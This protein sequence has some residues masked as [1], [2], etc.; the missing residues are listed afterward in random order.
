MASYRHTKV[1]LYCGTI[2]YLSQT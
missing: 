1:A 2:P